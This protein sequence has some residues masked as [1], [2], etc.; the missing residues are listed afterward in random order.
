MLAPRLATD[1]PNQRALVDRL[2]L[3]SDRPVVALLPGAE[4]GPAK[5]W[6]IEN[7]GAL[8]ARLAQAGASVWVLGSAREKPIGDR[9]TDL[10]C[11]PNV[12]NLC[13]ASTLVDA[14]DLLAAA[15]VVVS[16][17]SGLMHVAAAVGAHVVAI[18]GSTSP[19]FTPPLTDSKTICYEN[20]SCSPCFERHCPLKHLNCL[21]G[22]TV[23]AVHEATMTAL[24]ANASGERSSGQSRIS[25]DG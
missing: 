17:D 23:H 8:A 12:H 9:V 1:L 13:G 7:F 16:N 18:Y 20:L 21:R 19:V 14:I 10:A 6:P 15:A 22:I 4:Y 11:D 25:A 2:R 5:R 3:A 24:A